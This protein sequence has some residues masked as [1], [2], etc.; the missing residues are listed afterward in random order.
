M[1]SSAAASSITDRRRRCATICNCAGASFGCEPME[2]IAAII[3]A[4]LV[5]RAWA[6]VFAR[7]GWRVRLYDN[8]PSQVEQARAH[9]AASLTEQQA[10][11]LISDAE[12]AAARVAM[13]ERIEDAV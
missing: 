1:C 5:G 3:G 6:M 7:A 4:G 9:I 2:P 12:G 11:G 13:A 8:A 10:V